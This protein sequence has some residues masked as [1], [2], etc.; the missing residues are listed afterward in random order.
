MS[1]THFLRD[2]PKVQLHCHLEGTV[3]PATFLSLA[4]RNGVDARYRPSLSGTKRPAASELTSVDAANVYDFRSFAEFL[5][6][7]ASVCR[8]LQAPEDYAA[9]ARGYVEE[10]LAENVM[11]AEIFISP[12]VWLFFHP[13]LDVRYCIGAMRDVFEHCR[14]QHGVEI[15][16]ICDLTRNFGVGSAMRTAR[17]AASMKDLG[18]IGVGLGGDET[19]FPAAPFAAAFAFARENG[20]RTVAHAGEAD[21]PQSVRAAVEVLGAER[22]G[23]GVRSIEDPNVIELLIRQG[24]ALE[25]CPTSNYFTGAVQP[26]M[27]HPFIALDR[28]GVTITI[29][30]D[31]PAMFRT[32]LECEYQFVERA[33]GLETA[34]RLARNG[35]E[36]SFADFATKERMRERFDRYCAEVIEQRRSP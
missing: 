18:V 36:A 25:V 11:Y 34:L 22:I 7:F 23:H 24:V 31:D 14:A 29:D 27:P 8:S 1:S 28:A 6:A 20:L 35:I 33:A 13:A 21:G 9:I 10:A 19:K 5:L 3:Q 4:A 2:L 17:L 26:G 30:A 15:K 12:S 16:I 32:N